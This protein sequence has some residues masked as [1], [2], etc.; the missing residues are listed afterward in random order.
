MSP[1][2]T[3]GLR[4]AMMIETDGPGGAEVML[5]QL[6]EE[7][8]ARGHVVT[9]VG[10]ARGRGWLSGRLRSLGFERRTFTL[11][12][13]LDPGCAWR[14][15]RTLRELGTDVVHSHEFT[16][17]VYGTAAAGWLRLPHVITMHG[18]EAV[19]DAWRRRVA[20][21]WAARHSRALVAVSAHTRDTMGQGL[22]L[23]ADAIRVIPNGVP[24]GTGERVATRR[25]L[26]VDDDEV[27]ILTVG[28]LRPRKGH[29]VLLDALGRVQREGCTVP[30]QLAIA[31]DGRERENLAR[32]AA[33]LGLAERV[34][35]LGHRDDV[36]D[37]QAA[38]DVYAMPSFWEG[39]PLAVLEAMVAG[40]A[41]AAS[42]V[43]GIPE[44]IRDGET[45]LLVRAFDAEALA[46]ALRRLL[47][48]PALRRRLGENAARTAAAEYAVGR[49]AD[50][51]ERLY[52]GDAPAAA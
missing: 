8:R 26:G 28:N 21:R 46:D 13:P 10:P 9:P 11:R 19:L 5:V 35:L 1:V 45:G 29:V 48:D 36:P 24:L 32:Q 27:L 42:R 52:R 3:R 39:L 14:L 37:L 30:W 43:G 2:E 4:I 51:Y 16:M 17:A 18:N 41:I 15:V 33:A 20:L 44:A 22:H 31:G 34:Q 40:N 12:R 49:M 6:A 23:A 7:L 47:E 25:K 38:A 50:R